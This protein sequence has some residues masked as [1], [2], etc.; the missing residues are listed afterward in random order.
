[1]R[2][3]ALITTLGTTLGLAA[4]G[5]DD[6]PVQPSWQV[7][8][9]PVL[10]ANCV[11]CHTYPTLG[12]AAPG[13]RLDSYD[14]V[15]VVEFDAPIDGAAHNATLIAQ[16][17]QYSKYR[18]GLTV[19]PPG[20]EMG[21]YEIGV[22]RNWGGLVDGSMMAPRGPGRADNR[23]PE[24]TLTELGR[25]ASYVVFGYEVRDADR[26][27]VVGSLYG[28]R[29]DAGNRLVTDV[30]GDL[31]SGRGTFA[32]SLV[33]IAAGSYELTAR[34][35]DGADVDG[36]EGTNDFVELSLGMLVLP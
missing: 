31:T 27:L 34:L 3:L 36:P 4:C 24:L 2:A 35:D 7:D 32:V 29:L 26:D 20:R 6:P 11:R 10:A 25:D 19:M 30:I 28:P 17:I 15:E 14:P 5:L 23:A 22:L 13:L 16:R 21:D 9:M 1:M 33:G 8:V 12:F 18:P